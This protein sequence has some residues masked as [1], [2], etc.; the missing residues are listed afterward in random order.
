MSKDQ[1]DTVVL[2]SGGLDSTV[3]A[4]HLRDKGR[5]IRMISFDYGQR[6]RRE[7]QA[8]ALV[9][10]ALRVTHDVV[11][12]SVLGRLLGGSALTDDSVAVPDG[13]YTDSSMQATIVPNRNA[14]LTAIAVGI[15]SA[16]GCGQVALGVHAGDHPVYPDCRPDFVELAD[17]IAQAATANTVRVMAPFVTWSKGEI[18]GH[19]AALGV[20]YDLTWSCYRG[21]L[22]H[23]GRCGTCVERREAFELAGVPDPTG[24]VGGGH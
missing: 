14:I 1:A 21:E 24:Y 9:G 2:A 16:H 13:H 6:H 10:T 17:R 3:L 8:A 23:C 18:V 7:L 12:L 4:Y 20:P 5:R 19:G 15:A 22:L 11:D